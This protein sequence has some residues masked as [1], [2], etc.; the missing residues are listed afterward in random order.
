MNVRA[1]V[2]SWFAIVGMVVV[3]ILIAFGLI[4]LLRE[5][6]ATNSSVATRQFPTPRVESDPPRDLAEYRREQRA[7][8]EGYRWIDRKAGVVHIPI[9]RAMEIL[10]QQHGPMAGQRRDSATE[11][12]HGALPAQVRPPGAEPQPGPEPP[13]A[14]EGGGCATTP[15]D[16]QRRVGVAPRLGKT[17]P[18]SLSFRDER[19]QPVSFL[20]VLHNKP[21]ILAL[22]YYGCSNLCS[23]TLRN[24]GGSLHRLDLTPGRDFEIV[25]VSIDPRDGPA[26]ARSKLTEYLGRFGRPPSQNCAGCDAGWHFLTGTRAQSAALAQSVGF[27]YFWDATQ[28]QYAH[29]A[30]IVILSPRGEVTQYFNGIEFPPR[31][32]REALVNASAGRVNSLSDRLWLLCYHYEALIGP[33]SAYITT[34]LRILAIG[35]IAGLAALII[36]LV[37][38]SP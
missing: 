15:R 19:G 6:R 20:E 27:R 32:L 26:M 2:A 25:A 3:S 22:V 30:G 12:R 10:E 4:G 38:T 18:G 37:R 13:S 14:R 16:I 23:M 7:R 34:A 9:E 1:I 21:A 33:Y 24:I 28:T 35:L 31:E 5:H 36:R 11:Q 17:V 29:P 8:I